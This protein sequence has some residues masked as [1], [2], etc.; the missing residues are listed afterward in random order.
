LGVWGAVA[1]QIDEPP[2]LILDDPF[3]GLDPERR[4]R[5]T[6]GLAERGQVLISVPDQAQV[7]SGATVWELEGG[8]VEAR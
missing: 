6:E 5:L 8:S 7:P 3:S 4:T 1:A 2:I